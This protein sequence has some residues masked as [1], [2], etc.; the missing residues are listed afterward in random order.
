SDFV[1]Q[2]GRNTRRSQGLGVRAGVAGRAL[3]D[4]LTF[5]LDAIVEA[6][7]GPPDIGAA[8]VDRQQVVE[9]RGRAVGDA[10]VERQR[11]DPFGLELSVAAPEPGEVLDPRHLEPDEIDR[12]VGDPLRVGL[13]EAN[14]HLSGE[15]E[16]HG[17]ATYYRGRCA[18]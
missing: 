8:G 9:A 3:G 17:R 5:A 10:G 16:V 1:D 12:V 7:P 14:L 11:L 6:K 15:S 2:P 13:G 4:Q 18:A